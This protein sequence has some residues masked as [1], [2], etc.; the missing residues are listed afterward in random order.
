MT[1]AGGTGGAA[2]T[3]GQGSPTAGTNGL[4]GTIYKMKVTL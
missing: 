3:L 2:G 4:P 1:A